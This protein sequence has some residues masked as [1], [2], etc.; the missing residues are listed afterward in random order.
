M[1]VSFVLDSELYLY[2]T[3]HFE[4][5]IEYIGFCTPRLIA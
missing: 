2:S 3:I 1:Y 4:G 5:Y